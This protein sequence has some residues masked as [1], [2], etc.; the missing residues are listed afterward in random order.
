MSKRGR[1]NKKQSSANSTEP[2]AIAMED[3]PFA[4]VEEVEE[5]QVAQTASNEKL[6][7]ETDSKP[8]DSRISEVSALLAEASIAVN[9]I[10]RPKRKA[11]RVPGSAS[12][13]SELP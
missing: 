7:G 1:K 6:A 4:P 8:K 11:A 12:R 9:E 13:S 3:E 2:V 5:E 10:S